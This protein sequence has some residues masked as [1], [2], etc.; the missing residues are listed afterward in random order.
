MSTCSV[1][2]VNT[3]GRSQWSD[4]VSFRSS[5]SLNT[6]IIKVQ[7]MNADAIGDFGNG[8]LIHRP[9]ARA[10]SPHHSVEADGGKEYENTNIRSDTSCHNSPRIRSGAG[11]DVNFI[12]CLR[13]E[14]LRWDIFVN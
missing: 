5:P 2:V 14:E 8:D 9:S 10:R 7:D 11:G 4:L 1:P 12:C 3:D 13:Y 6:V